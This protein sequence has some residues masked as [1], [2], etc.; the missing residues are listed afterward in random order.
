ALAA[1]S[2]GPHVLTNET[3]GSWMEAAIAEADAGL[4]AGGLP[5]GAVVA[6][7]DGIVLA[8]ASSRRHATGAAVGHAEIEALRRAGRALGGMPGLV[9][10][11]TVEPC[12]MC[13]AAAVEAGIHTVGFARAAPDNGG[14]AVVSARGDGAT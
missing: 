3:L 13:L 8:L 6:R 14:R 2:A 7:V 5:F 4:D 10:V 12:A 1:A 9:L 11:T